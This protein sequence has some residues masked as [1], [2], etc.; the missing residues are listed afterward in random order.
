MFWHD[1]FSVIP[2]HCK[3]NLLLTFKHIKLTRYNCSGAK[4]ILH[5]L[6]TV[7]MEVLRDLASLSLNCEIF[8]LVC[9]CL[10]LLTFYFCEKIKIKCFI[11]CQLLRIRLKFKTL[12]FFFNRD[13]QFKQSLLWGYCV[14]KGTEGIIDQVW[15]TVTFFLP[16]LFY[17]YLLK[18]PY[19]ILCL[20]I[21]EEVLHKTYPKHNMKYLWA[22]CTYT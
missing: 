19:F 14:F 7:E 22:Y 15:C 16:E 8:N 20:T 1:W 4:Y 13:P 18:I 12:N 9:L 5:L 21:L 3:L 10:V 17:V 2:A 11:F 6:W